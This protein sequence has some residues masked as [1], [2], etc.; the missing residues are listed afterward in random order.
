[1]DRFPGHVC[2]AIGLLFVA[3][4]LASCAHRP[5]AFDV[6]IQS[7]GQKIQLR[8]ELYGSWARIEMGR[9]KGYDATTRTAY[10]YMFDL[11]TSEAIRYGYLS[12]DTEGVDRPGNPLFFNGHPIGFLSRGGYGSGGHEPFYA[13]QNGVKKRVS[14]SR[15]HRYLPASYFKPGTNVLSFGQQ[16]LRSAKKSGGLSYERFTIKE[17]NI[18]VYKVR[19]LD[20]G[21]SSVRQ[22]DIR[23]FP[24]QFEFF[25]A[26]TDE[27]L[28][29]ALIKLP[30]LLAE[31]SDPGS[32][33]VNS[34]SYVYA[35]IGDYYRWTGFYNKSLDY[36]KKA[37]AMQAE[38]SLTLLTPRIRS[39]LGLAYYFVG[40]YQS[41][42]TECEKAAEEIDR[43]RDSWSHPVSL[44]E[45]ENTDRLEG[46]ASAYLA[47]SFERLGSRSEAEYYA[48]RIIL[49]F[50]DDWAH[51]KNRQTVIGQY[52]PV[53]LAHQLVGEIA[54]TDAS[55]DD[56]LEH[57]RKAATYLSYEVR[58][59]IY[60]DQLMIIQLGIAKT[61]F[62]M[63]QYRQA[64]EIL[65][66]VENPTNAFMWRS[67]LLQGQIAE[68][69]NDFENAAEL[70]LESI[71][72]IEFSR[73]RLT[74]HG[75]KINFMSDK[76]A[77]Y[78]RMIQ[79]LTRLEKYAEAFEYAEKA[80]ARAFLDL[81]ARTEKIVGQK[82]EALSELTQ[83]EKRLQELLLTVQHQQD[84]NRQLFDTRGGD[85]PL[86]EEIENTRTM[87]RRFF[88][89]WFKANK[90][91]ASLRSA[92]TLDARSVKELLSGEAGLI[93]YFYDDRHL[94]AWI[95][96][97]ERFDCVV[98]E[99]EESD[100]VDLVKN[101]REMMRPPKDVRSLAVVEGGASSRKI[102]PTQL[103]NRI[104]RLL[105]EDIFDRL[106][107]GR[108]YLVPHG[109]LHYLPLQSLLV[110]GR[111]LV[112]R[113]QIG[114]APSASVLRHVFEKNRNKW[115]R[116]LALGNP[117][118]DVSG[119]DLQ[120][121]EEEVR[122][123]QSVFS[124]T[125]VL[126]RA[127][128]TEA[129][130]KENAANYDI[131]HVASHGEFNP[132]AP[133]RS[134]LRLRSGKGED[135]RLETQ[136]IFDLDLNAY[137]ISLSACNTGLGKITSGDEM[138]GMTRAFIFAGTPSILATFWSVN[139]ASTRKLMRNFYANLK[140]MDKFR[141]LQMAQISMIHD[142]DYSHP[143]YWA[144][145]QIIGDYR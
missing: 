46:L 38:K 78:A 99:I 45:H 52:L 8:Q 145:F 18:V 20:G 59:E 64:Q 63:D 48:H 31:L 50:K 1:M 68:A 128:A 79:C 100:L 15:T 118:L 60:N 90:D 81:I 33:Y 67:F 112:E 130:F 44:M 123:I 87:L 21:Y 88:S 19:T 77:P 57:Y 144:G 136:E 101:Y 119:M 134:C 23:S 17:V 135:G 83:E 12:I 98:K 113:Y 56:A 72:E 30:S 66:S 36:Q 51:F 32:E 86:T 58:P 37:M 131:L 93:E 25:S 49:N 71:R 104:S 106:P 55:F 41:A 115:E 80:K 34:L 102:S 133:M 107:D 10:D 2:F 92:D 94:Y 137:L 91:F 9:G 108:I 14:L 69:Q 96:S 26:L 120:F 47:L 129:A 24:K 27:E 11:D 82:N 126:T 28:Y 4:V 97:R 103:N 127:D 116:I 138:T 22:G 76:Q 140:T 40:D 13:G 139:D 141:S 111:Y 122:D 109:V 114:Y 143:Y 95:L 89:R 39:R 42:V 110:D 54:L 142:E 132:D 75:L 5:S 73:T 6:V 35:K 74:S 7:G 3:S 29:I 125:R 43:I 16:T 84:M 53:V 121:A 105:V 117:D 85:V 61:L 62:H 65:S 70:Y 124:D